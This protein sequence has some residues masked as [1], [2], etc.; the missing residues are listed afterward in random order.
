MKNIKDLFEELKQSVDLFKWYEGE[1]SYYTLEKISGIVEEI[2]QLDPD[3]KV[4]KSVITLE[5]EVYRYTPPMS[6]CERMCRAAS[7][8]WRNPLTSH[9][10]Y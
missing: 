8:A 2:L 7:E 6:Y 4:R 1:S 9:V 5:K 10:I 3:E